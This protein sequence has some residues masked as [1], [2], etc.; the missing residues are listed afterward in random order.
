M[1]ENGAE[2]FGKTTGF[3]GRNVLKIRRRYKINHR[4][5]PDAAEHLL[6]LQ[7][8]PTQPTRRGGFMIWRISIAKTSRTSLLV[9][10]G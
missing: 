7:Q 6:F 2:W 9:I 5:F 10:A 4:P 3:R 8:S 1:E